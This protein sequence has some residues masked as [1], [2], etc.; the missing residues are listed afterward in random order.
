METKQSL[1]A[2]LASIQVKATALAEKARSGDM[3]DSELTELQGLADRATEVKAKLNGVRRA[4]QMGQIAAGAAAGDESPHGPAD[5]SKGYLNFSPER[6]AALALKMSEPGV[7]ALLA[8]GSTGT[9]VALDPAPLRTPGARQAAGLFSYFEAKRQDTPD[10]RYIRQTVRTSSAA[11]VA[12]G[13]VK[14]TSVFTTEDVA[15]HL[16]VVAH[17]SEYVDKYLLEDN[18]ELRMFLE[19]ELSDG[20][21]NAAER[22]ALAKIAAT[23]GVQTVTTSAGFTPIKGYDAVHN[24]IVK[25]Q[26]LGFTPDLIVINPADYEALRLGKNAQNDYVGGSPFDGS[27]DPQL[28]ARETFVTAAQP[29][30]KVLVLPT[31]AVRISTDRQGV[32]T[33][34]DAATGFDTNRVRFRTEGRFATDVRRPAGIVLVTL[35]A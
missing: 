6:R 24:G 32:R 30:G 1:E 28:W 29:A 5:G 34:V 20:V 21:I 2:D 19:A 4:E 3:T 33:D 9:A 25:S 15:G 14:P 10:Y 16:D 18:D 17:L 12:P 13:G 27:G 31:A 26:S 35:T 11:V 8:T 22:A 7:K 23:S